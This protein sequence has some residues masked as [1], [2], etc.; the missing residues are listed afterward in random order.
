MIKKIHILCFC[1]LLCLFIGT[2]SA[3]EDSN[4]NTSDSQ[5][6]S[7]IETKNIEMFYKD[8]TSFDVKVV[9]NDDTISIEKVNFTVNG[10]TYNRK[11][12]S[13]GEA[14]LNI[15]L[16]PGEYKIKT[17]FLSNNQKFSVFNTIKIKEMNSTLIADKIVE[18]GYKEGKYSVTLL[19]G[20]NKPLADKTVIFSVNGMQYTKTTDKNG[21]ASLNINLNPSIYPISAKFS[22]PFHTPASTSSALDV[23][24]YNTKFISNTSRFNKTNVEYAVKLV[25]NNKNPV[26]N[27]Y[28]LFSL[29]GKSSFVKT[30]EN[31][32]A[33]FKKVLNPGKY[34]ISFEF[35][36][37]TGYYGSL[38]HNT[39]EVTSNDSDISESAVK[40]E[41]NDIEMFYKDGTSFDVR[42]LEN[43]Q[44]VEGKKISITV[45]GE[46]YYR[47]SDSLEPAKL[48]INL[49]PGEYAIFTNVT[50]NNQTLSA[51]N[52]IIIKPMNSTLIGDKEVELGYKQG[53]YGVTLIG[54]NNK[55]LAGK[56]VIFSVNGIDYTKTTKEDGSASLSINLEPGTYPISVRFS[57]IFHTSTSISSRITVGIY[58]TKF[59][60]N[61]SK[62]N[63]SSVEY[64]VKL[65]DDKNRPV[66]GAMVLFYLNGIFKGYETDENGVATFKDVLKEGSYEISFSFAG[67]SGYLKSSGVN[68]FEVTYLDVII[69]SQDFETCVD[70][71][72][73]YLV[74]ITDSDNS[75]LVNETI[76]SD[77]YQDN[78]FIKTVESKTF[79]DGVARVN[80][81][82]SPGKYT[83]KN[84]LNE[85]SLS[86]SSIVI[87]KPA[88]MVLNSSNLYLNRKGE[89]YTITLRNNETNSPLANKQLTF[90]INGVDYKRTTND[91]GEASLKINLNGGEYNITYHVYGG[92]KYADL[93]GS[94]IIKV[95]N[96]KLASNI[97]ILTSDIIR[98]GTYC[99]V[100]L[101]DVNGI[102]LAGK[103]VYISV[104]GI[105]YKKIT[106]D[107]GIA[108]LKINLR[109]GTYNLKVSFDGDNLFFHSAINGDMVVS[110]QPTF[111]YT[112][113][114]KGTESYNGFTCPFIRE[115]TIDYNNARYELDFASD[116]NYP[117]ITDKNSYLI[118]SEGIETSY[119]IKQGLEF[120]SLN[121]NVLI[122]FYGKTSDIGQFSVIFLY[123]NETFKIEYVVDNEI[124]ATVNMCSFY[125][126]EDYAKL[127]DLGFRFS[128]PDFANSTF[129]SSNHTFTRQVLLEAPATTISFK[130]HPS[131]NDFDTIQTYILTSE[132]IT[133]QVMENEMSK[134]LDFNGEYVK[135]AFELYLSGLMTMWSVDGYSKEFAE[136]LNITWNKDVQMILVTI[137]WAQ[138][139]LDAYTSLNVWGNETNS[140]LFKLYYGFL[141]SVCEEFGLQSTGNNASSSVNKIFNGI[142][143]G[144]DFIIDEKDGKLTIKLV[145][146][147]D[148]FIIDKVT[149]DVMA[150]VVFDIDTF[151]SN[152]VFKGSVS[153][154]CTSI[155]PRI[156][157][158]FG[159]IQN[160]FL[161]DSKNFLNAFNFFSLKPEL[162]M[163][164]IVDAS[165]PATS[166]FVTLLSKSATASVLAFN[167]GVTFQEYTLNYR[168]RYAPED[169]WQY[170]ASH[171]SVSDV[172]TIAVVNNKTYYTDYIEIPYDDRGNIDIEKGIYIDS[173]TGRR[174]LTQYEKDKYVSYK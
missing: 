110:T 17:D 11:I 147:S 6:E 67:S 26:K 40:L 102:A 4:L 104:N 135:Y 10:V 62:F 112:L 27:H 29:Q 99:S 166:F 118:T 33:T 18:L 174:N 131:F 55:P 66:K 44:G 47:T 25:F 73:P 145:N 2:V 155:Q 173:V 139:S 170:Y 51:V 14:K 71:P 42:I 101:V 156:E 68:T 77:I 158:T 171:G 45:N 50:V 152:L 136:N 56:T 59:I 165:F 89:F 159:Y 113:S 88:S 151:I 134:A 107:K 168:N 100:K 148:K 61:S 36:G 90:T 123:D 164:Q 150:L 111:N 117:L 141:F 53:K 32:I 63:K 74:F 160:R 69:K 86:N 72:I 22:E 79:E 82:L 76:K 162:I 116:R 144:N 119:T 106:D 31:G 108:K 122:T 137:D 9:N 80:L 93:T 172:R 43:G 157:N 167:L 34:T 121:G 83:V 8:G 105:S 91:K 115:F 60:S 21:V 114:I 3:N 24:I 109:D 5:V 143:E 87:I 120:K 57:D 146:A 30:D 128:T 97:H 161:K 13:S 23:R 49:C 153:E 149:G 130:N 41:T 138:L 38:G 65:M 64:S 129:K 96:D 78:K 85:N 169:A 19:G 142:Y 94:N 95:T 28:V 7:H 124:V 52:T 81:D 163:K 46:T 98:K 127:V 15:N 39:F 92:S 54:G 132:K 35:L 70:G 84:Y 48:A 1:I 20:Y 58:G 126:Y 75:R 125:Y 12:N 133:G 140:R 16:V 103:E 37:S 154:H